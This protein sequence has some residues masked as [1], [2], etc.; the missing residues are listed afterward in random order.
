[1]TDHQAAAPTPGP[2]HAAPYRGLRVLDF[3]QG[4]ASPYCGFLLAAYGA[5][6]IKVEPPEGDWSRR[7]G[8]AYGEHS[9]LS[10]VY[11]RGKRNLC[12]DLKNAQALAVAH[13]LARAADVFIEGLRPGVMARLGL[14]YETLRRDNERLIYVSISGFGQHGPYAQRPASDSIAQAFSG[15]IS[16]NV[17]DDGIPHRVGHTISDVTT[18]LYAFQAVATALFARAAVGTGRW[19]DV[20]LTQSTAAVLGR[21]LAEH[22]LEGGAPRALNVPAGTYR[23]R[24]GWLMV[25]LV[26]EAQYQRL[27]AELGR[28]DL[29]TDPRFSDFARRADNAAGLMQ[30]LRTVFVRDTTETWLTKLLAA[31]ILAERILDPSEWLAN[32]HVGHIGGALCADT[33]GVGSI[34][35]AR[36]PG[37]VGDTETTLAPSAALG[38]HSRAI[39]REAGY[40][41]AVIDDLIRGGAVRA[42][43]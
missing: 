30:E 25:T 7:L 32:P 33:P 37:T 8:T 21:K 38:Q 27:C 31:D 22:V 10:A 12:L 41:A 23:T 26:K 15:L 19:L 16:V 2:T 18:G 35:A 17:G 29:A 1:M 42:P 14:G 34:H 6:V 40:D 11:N 5:D 43:A 24:D 28:D 13:R 3:G 39:L 20:S 9:A 4:V 36:T